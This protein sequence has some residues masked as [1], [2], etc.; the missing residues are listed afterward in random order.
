MTDR[1]EFDLA[2]AVGPTRRLNRV[3]CW[4]FLAGSAFLGIGWILDALPFLL[5][6]PHPFVLCTKYLVCTEVPRS[7]YW[8]TFIAETVIFLGAAGYLI[9]L[10]LS[11]FRRGASRLA[12]G[13]DG[14]RFTMNLGPPRLVRWPTGWRSIQIIDYREEPKEKRV[15]GIQGSVRLWARTVGLTG[16]AIEAILSAA[17]TRGLEVR[18]VRVDATRTSEDPGCLVLHT[19]RARKSGRQE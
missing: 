6:S 1:V 14:L 13:P 17:R 12:L 16:D 9:G 15:S 3:G 4:V 8:S 7:Q 5:Q 19:I 11:L 10:A 18:T 2:S